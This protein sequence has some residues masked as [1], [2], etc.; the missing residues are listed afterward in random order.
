M[1]DAALP[2]RALEDLG[3]RLHEALVGVGDDAFDPA[4]APL[5]QPA[6]EGLPRHRGL[7]VHDPEAD[8]PA[9]PVVAAAYGGDDALG[10][11]VALIAAV[12]VG[13]VEPQVGELHPVEV[14]RHAR[15]ARRAQ[16]AELQRVGG[17][18]DLAGREPPDVDL[19]DDGDHGP[20]DPRVGP[21]QLVG[22]VRPL[23]QLWYPQR[24]L[25]DRGQQPALPVAVAPVPLAAQLVCLPV[26]DLVDHRL[27][28]HPGE[29]DEVD[30]PVLSEREVL[31]SF[32]FL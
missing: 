7:G 3:Y 1:H 9:R 11:H 5:A 30:R 19:L 27:Q 31:Q 28:L 21:D 8:E 16:A 23:P 17:L 29:L 26:H 4:H 15:D 13:G 12:Q 25:A 22:E 32:L 6:Q 18:L 2:G 14:G 24:Y 20:V 10:L